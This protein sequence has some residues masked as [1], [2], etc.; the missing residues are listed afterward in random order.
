MNKALDDS[1]AWYYTYEE[2]R[3]TNYAAEPS[4]ESLLLIGPL[5]VQLIDLLPTN[6]LVTGKVVETIAGPYYATIVE[7]CN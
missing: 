4:F 5:F 3:E 6:N 2:K 7:S 1:S